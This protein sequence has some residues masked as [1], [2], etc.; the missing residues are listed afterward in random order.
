MAKLRWVRL[1]VAMA[2]VLGTCGQPAAFPAVPD[3]KYTGA[4]SLTN[5]Y[6]TGSLPLTLE[7]SGAAV[8]GSF[9]AEIWMA[10][11][12]IEWG[13]W[14]IGL[15]G[16]CDQQ[17]TVK[18]S[19]SLVAHEK[20]SPGASREELEGGSFTATAKDG[21]IV[22]S[23]S[24]PRFSCKFDVGGGN[25]E[26]PPTEAGVAVQ[27]TISTDPPHPKPGDKITVSATVT[28]PDGKPLEGANT[29][30]DVGS[31]AGN[32]DP[33]FT[34]D[35]KPVTIKLK[36]IYKENEY[37]FSH[38]LAAY[39]EP[40]PPGGKDQPTASPDSPGPV[41]GLGGAGQVPG[42]RTVT[43]GIVGTVVPGLIGIIGGLLSGLRSASS[44]LAP[45]APTPPP[46]PTQPPLGAPTP[47]APGG[48]T[49]V[50]KP[51]EAAGGTSP[52]GAAEALR[53]RLDHLT[54]LAETTKNPSL[55][56]W[57]EKAGRDAFR[58]DGTVDQDKLA[59]LKQGLS[60]ALKLTPGSAQPGVVDGVVSGVVAGFGTLWDVGAALGDGARSF[61]GGLASI[62]GAVVEGFRGIAKGITNLTYLRSGLDE[63]TKDWVNQSAGVERKEFGE[64]LTDGRVLDA[65][66]SLT[67][68][69][70]KTGVAA[71]S[72]AAEKGW[73]V[74]RELLPVE[75][76]KS[77]FD[78][79]ASLEERAWAI[80]SAIIKVVGI[81][82]ISEGGQGLLRGRAPFLPEG[83]GSP[84]ISGAEK[85][86]G[87]GNALVTKLWPAPPLPTEAIGLRGAMGELQD[88]IAE[89][90][91]A[92]TEA[93]RVEKIRE[94]YRSG[95]MKKL[96][97]LQ[98]EGGLAA[99]QARELNRVMTQTVDDVVDQS[100]REVVGGFEAEVTVDGTPVKFRIKE[101]IVVDSGSSAGGGARSILTDADR[102][103]GFTFEGPLDKNGMPYELS[104]AQHQRLSELAGR[105]VDRRARA[106]L[107]D[108]GLTQDDVR[109]GSYRG[110]GES[111][112]GAVDSYPRP[113]AEQNAI[114]KSRATSY[115]RTADGQVSAH[116]ISGQAAVDQ[117]HL[118]ELRHSGTALS[119]SR[120]TVGSARRIVKQQQAAVNKAGLTPDKAAKAV[121]RTHVE[122]SRFGGRVDPELVKIAK[123][124][125]DD[126]QGSH[127]ILQGARLTSEEFADWTRAA[128]KGAAKWL[129]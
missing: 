16:T 100:T 56:E 87:A 66:G 27:A 113:Y 92:G 26:A 61:F 77:F 20:N 101:A 71:L 38:S 105:S 59:A 62:P 44:R 67:K 22:G 116:Q 57:A 107:A 64:A 111:P 2:A 9:T 69:F 58:P 21:R 123:Q 6:G 13:T 95:G 126:P 99:Q 5:H 8:D 24:A 47:P 33:Q 35:G 104:P 23:G 97:R 110:F 90:V 120:N 102:T 106:G 121:G 14:T 83:W 129:D 32:A 79:N 30:W 127:Y 49:T 78:A 15:H 70:G 85:L 29:I 109:Y 114:V 55:K 48:A 45:T 52:L 10:S 82:M 125:K 72:R 42:P 1:L 93:E 88:K 63:I 73:G 11:H 89:A 65:L 50:E 98:E 103:H 39:T 117:A 119:D 108:S 75:E 118:T 81:M 31:Y 94:L 19:M 60:D 46:R 12:T 124:I 51:P 28:G 40:A 43:E 25:P 41:S 53:N 96:S 3:G 115:S 86:R 17:G 54:H 37:G 76:A 68:G 4:V 36:V 112:G 128:I 74:V 122:T 34:W 7:V 91:G 84:L 18:G 80:P